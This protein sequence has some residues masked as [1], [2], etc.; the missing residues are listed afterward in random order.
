MRQYVMTLL[1]L[2]AALMGR[3]Q[4][5]DD[6]RPM[7]VE[8]RSWR[9]VE[10]S[11]GGPKYEFTYTIKGDTV[12]GG[13]TFKKLYVLRERSYRDKTMH[14]CLAMQEADRKVYIVR[15]GET[16][17]AKLYDFSLG[18]GDVV[19]GVYD[20][21]IGK[22]VD[23]PLSKGCSL[24]VVR[25]DTISLDYGSF[26]RLLLRQEAVDDK[27]KESAGAYGHLVWIEG[28]GAHNLLESVGTGTTIS[29]WNYIM[30]Y[31][32]QDGRPIFTASDFSRLA[33]PVGYHPLL[34]EGKRWNYLSKPDGK[35]FAYEVRGDTLLNEVEGFI[36]PLPCK[37]LYYVSV[38][39]AAY[40]CALYEDA[41]ERKVYCIR[42]G[43]CSS[44]TLYNYGL[45]LLEDTP[46]DYSLISKL[47]FPYF[48]TGWQPVT[49]QGRGLR[50]EV[51]E[52]DPIH[53]QFSMD[54]PVAEHI[55]WVEGVGSSAGLWPYPDAANL[56][57]AA[58]EEL[59]VFMSC[60]EDGACIATKDDFEAVGLT[61]PVENV[62]R[63]V[64][65]IAPT[66]IAIFDLQ[67]RRLAAK[68]QRGVYIQGGRKYV[69][70]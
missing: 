42:P 20:G 56:S 30:Q 27:G 41:D 28:V 13:E 22:L 17:K 45:R 66:G 14:Y 16:V 2:C 40:H 34:K 70:R 32:E 59:P 51:L 33:P 54:A 61:L 68:P 18:E 53:W 4:Q 23:A 38:D 62:C 50:M 58:G 65:G 24:T 21:L 15:A 60:Y 49:M 43:H 48:M 11:A 64:Q 5:S 67:G 19:Y 57:D 9:G 26:R 10:Q 47:Y 29:G 44:V 39:S 6:Y 37:K 31:C 55:C 12:I 63:D 1:L 7:L 36:A 8:G 69:V 25:V 3:A 35:A 52:V 46:S